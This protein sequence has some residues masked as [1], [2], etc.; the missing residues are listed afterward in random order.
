MGLLSKF[1][2]LD[3]YQSVDHEATKQTGIGALVSLSC[4]TIIGWLVFSEV[5]S[6]I[7]PAITSHMYVDSPTAPSSLSSESPP[8]ESLPLGSTLQVNM[9]LSLPLVPCAVVSVDAQD[10]MGG[11]ILNLG[12]QLLK[13]RLDA[14]GNNKQDSAGKILLHRDEPEG[15]EDSRDLSDQIGEGCRLRGW[16]KVKKVPGNF[17]ISAHT[18][19]DKLRALLGDTPLNMTHTVNHLWFGDNPELLRVSEAVT[20]PLRGLK[21]IARRGGE[22]GDGGEEGGVGE[23][24]AALGSMSATSFE[25]YVKIVPSALTQGDG[26]KHHSYQFVANSHAVVGRYRLPAIFFR[27]D[28]SPITVMFSRQGESLSH[29]LVQICAIVGG[30]FTVLGLVSSCMNRSLGALSRKNR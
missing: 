1:K 22:G 24:D 19:S 6:Y 3:V 12:G 23:E 17:H 10:V 15:M 2:S 21:R 4:I 27:Y 28:I 11:H 18:R 7:T 29:F 8:S 14:K 5:G 20:N 25:Y 26:Q 9:D 13:Q 16:F 30:V